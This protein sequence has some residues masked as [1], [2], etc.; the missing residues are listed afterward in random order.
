MKCSVFIATSADGFIATNDGG[1]DWLHTSGNTEV[2]LGDQ[3]DM[4]MSKFMDSVDCLIMGR[5][6]MEAISA[7]DLTPDQWPYRD[8]RVIVLS[9]TLNEPPENLKDKVEMYSGDIQELVSNL[10]DE[11][12]SRAYIDGGKTI[13]SF[14][15]LQLINDLTLTRVPVILGEGIPLFGKT[16]RPIKLESASAITFPNDFVQLRYAVSYE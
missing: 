1:I 16:K 12:Y 6:C 3:A 5:G 4:G 10:E 7:F 11:G 14:L 2:D 13:Q 9:R 8:A 15:D